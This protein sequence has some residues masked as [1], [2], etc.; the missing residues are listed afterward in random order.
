MTQKQKL[1]A[2]DFSTWLSQLRHAHM[3]GGDIDVNC[4]EC[5]GC[6]TSSYFIHIGPDEKQTVKRIPT[7]LLFPA[8]G[9]PKGHVLMGY[10]KHGSCPML[11]DS[12]CSIYKDRPLTCRQ[13]DCRIFA[14]VGTAAVEKD[15]AQINE[16]AERWEF[17]YPTNQDRDEHMAVQ[18]ALAFFQ[19]H[20]D[21][22]PEN[23]V[24]TNPSQLAL[25]AVKVYEVFL[26]GKE[27]A[28]SMNESPDYIARA[29][30]AADKTVKSKDDR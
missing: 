7:E 13:Y 25:F 3:T 1:S 20:K 27:S 6:C 22:F 4:G 28:E 30:M 21:S 10:D 5:I 24:P 9:L 16:Q 29:I 17:S 19:E 26:A 8:P 18:K 15:K 23:I 2:G 12:K 14:A 11:V